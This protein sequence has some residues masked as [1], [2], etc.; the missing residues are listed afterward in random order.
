MASDSARAPGELEEVFRTLD[1]ILAQIAIDVLAQ[2][3]IDCFVFDANASRLW[4][5]NALVP[6]RL[7]VPAADATEARERLEEAGLEN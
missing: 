4:G 1:P 6:A 7:M 3:G 2:A 5:S